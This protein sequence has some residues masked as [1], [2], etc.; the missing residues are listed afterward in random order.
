MTFSTSKPPE[1][2]AT[3]Q[4]TAPPELDLS[5]FVGNAYGGAPSFGY[6]NMQFTP[7]SQEVGETESSSRWKYLSK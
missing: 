5:K 7:P 3:P 2:V 4:P 1:P 6:P